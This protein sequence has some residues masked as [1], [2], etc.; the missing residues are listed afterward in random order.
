[1]TNSFVFLDSHGLSRYSFTLTWRNIVLLNDEPGPLVELIERDDLR[2]Q[3]VAPEQLERTIPFLVDTVRRH[4]FLKLPTTR[5][6][7]GM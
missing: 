6:D 1:M 5:D 2:A 4:K 7:L 3:R